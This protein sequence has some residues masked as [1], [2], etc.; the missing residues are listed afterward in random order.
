MINNERQYNNQNS[1]NVRY[2]NDYVGID[3]ENKVA[4]NAYAYEE[5]NLQTRNNSQTSFDALIE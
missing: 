1:A 4:Q 5:E 3:T 2:K